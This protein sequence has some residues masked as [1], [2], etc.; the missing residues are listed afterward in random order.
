MDTSVPAAPK[1]TQEKIRSLLDESKKITMSNLR[2][3]VVTLRVQLSSGT[4][5]GSDTFQIPSGRNFL[6]REIRGHFAFQQP[7]SE[8]AGAGTTM[9]TSF[10]LRDRM[11]AKALQARIALVNQD[12]SDLKVIESDIGQ[13][14][15][16]CLASILQAAGGA[17]I[18]FGEELPLL[19]PAV[20]TLRLDVT[21]RDATTAGVATE[22]GVTLIGSMVAITG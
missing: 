2:D 8:V 10:N 6:I 7:S 19:V 18:V 11:I 13:N 12:R 1:Y 4:L 9:A 20:D 22:Y 17:P 21:L 14:N 16:L 5:F 3:D 15:T